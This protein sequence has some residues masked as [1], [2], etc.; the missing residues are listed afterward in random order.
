[1]RKSMMTTYDFNSD[2][3]SALFLSCLAPSGVAQ[4]GAGG[5][6][7]NDTGS[8]AGRPSGPSRV[9]FHGFSS[10]PHPKP[11]FWVRKPGFPPREFLQGGGMS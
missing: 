6:L 4:C 10:P 3:G 8:A 11:A 1:M 5:G 9:F 2:K 7:P